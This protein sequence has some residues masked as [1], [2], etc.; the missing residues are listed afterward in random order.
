MKGSIVNYIVEAELCCGA[1]V[2]IKQNSLQ[3]NEYWERMSIGLAKPIDYQ[4]KL[5][6]EEF[7]CKYDTAAHSRLQSSLIMT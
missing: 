6:L 3:I 4:D 7:V 1:Q 5:K 2:Y